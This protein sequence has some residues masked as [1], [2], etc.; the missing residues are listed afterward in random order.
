MSAT[1]KAWVRKQ[2]W[3]AEQ[4]QERIDFVQPRRTKPAA[5]PVEGWRTKA[6]AMRRELGVKFGPIWPRLAP[7]YAPPRPSAVNAARRQ[8]RGQRGHLEG[9]TC[10]A[11]RSAA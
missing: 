9:C 11:H 6:R 2:Q 3:L 5:K 7:G 1:T 8:R 10:P 4:A